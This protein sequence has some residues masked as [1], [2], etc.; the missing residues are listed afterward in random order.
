MLTFFEF[1]SRRDSDIM[2]DI[3][4]CEYITTIGRINERHTF[5]EW[6]KIAEQS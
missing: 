6:E 5:S 4:L 2:S 3:V 1:L